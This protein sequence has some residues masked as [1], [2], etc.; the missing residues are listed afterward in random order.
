M[1]RTLYYLELGIPMN[2]SDDALDKILS[3]FMGQCAIYGIDCHYPLKNKAT[4][5]DKPLTPEAMQSSSGVAIPPCKPAKSE[6][7]QQPSVPI[8]FVWYDGCLYHEN[9]SRGLID[10]IEENCT[11]EQIGAVL[12]VRSKN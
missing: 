4:L 7:S 5:K 10:V 1:Q 11:V 6:V 9:S 8:Q 12:Y 3:G 2:M